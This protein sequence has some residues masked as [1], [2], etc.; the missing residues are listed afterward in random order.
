[1][2]AKV[3]INQIHIRSFGIGTK[4]LLPVGAVFI[5]LTIG[6]AMLIS[7]SNRNNLTSIKT[8]ELQRMSGILANMVNEMIDNAS[9]IA[10]SMERSDR[11]TQEIAQTALFGLYYADPGNYLNPYSIAD[12]P[13]PINEFGQTFALQ[14]NLSLLTQL[15]VNLQTNDLDGIGFYLISPFN[16]VPD[17]NPTLAIWIDHDEIVMRRFVEKGSDTQA[18]YYQVSIDDFQ[19]PSADYFDISSVYSLEP[20]AF[21][22]DLQLRQVDRPEVESLS[23]TDY[24]LDAP[25]S[26]VAFDG[27]IP[28]LR[29]MYPISVTLP[30][31]ETWEDTL[32]P[33]GIL[34]LEQRLDAE[35]IASFRSRLGLDLGFAR[36]DNILITSL[37]SNAQPYLNTTD[38]TISLDDNHYYFAGQ[39][40]GPAIYDLRA[41]V[42]SPQSEVQAL[43]N[44]LQSQIFLMAALIVLI[45]SV[46]V[47]LS[48]QVLVSRSLQVLMG[49]AKEIEK[50]EFSSRVTL[51]RNDELGQLA[52][53]FNTMAARVEELIGSLEERVGARTRDLKAAIDVSREITTVLELE[54]LL[55]E[56][57]K[58]TANTYQLYA[59]AVLLPDESRENLILSASIDSVGK[60]FANTT[61]FRIPMH[62]R[63]S[64][65]AQAASSHRS[66]VVNDVSKSEHYM[67]VDELSE[68]RSELAIPMMLG[69]RFLGVFDVQSRQ[70]H[71]F[72]EEEIAALEI[73]A[74]QTAIAVR[75]AQIF[76]ELRLAR[77]QAEQ[78]NQAKSAFLASVSHELRTPLNSIINFTEFVRHG[79]MGPVNQQQSDTLQEVIVA[80]QHLL[81]LIN[82]VL[83]MSKIE[84]GS[85]VL[86]IEDG[87]DPHS[88]LNSAIS[89][90]HSLIGDKPVKLLTNIEE[91]LPTIRADSQ[92][93]LQILLNITSNACKFT[94]EGHISFEARS[95][96]DHIL[97][98][99]RDTGPGISQDDKELV[100]G[101]FQQTETGL[102]TGGGTGLGSPSQKCWRKRMAGACGTKVRSAAAQRFSSR[103]R[104]VYLISIFQISVCRNEPH[105][106]KKKSALRRG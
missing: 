58:L 60:P 99:I 27:K 53:A 97:I 67:F 46:I 100:F 18:L 11:V 28:I 5:L 30:H 29:T 78:A 77:E 9:L 23:Q 10:Q 104:S 63:R 3:Q 2:T 69:E 93:I 47:Y 19:T 45:G 96:D 55:P 13:Q 49:G 102:R 70:P 34:V 79:M 65:I 38:Q 86:Y 40:T 31:P 105:D 24:R 17:A 8:A 21:Y 72:G 25:V 62:S 22:S 54:N 7:V 94:S 87:I 82:D 80:S 56:V 68:T 52:S 85:L 51:P 32:I 39:P 81:N 15:Q 44:Q 76:E 89:T 61:V 50:G 12:T 4:I 26:H 43:I 33:T 106:E 35:T 16:I 84:S 75:N 95:Q 73:L 1:M 64:I 37:M 57:V 90:A 36:G 74:K 6:L 48:I 42:F 83:D 91:R 71:S 103:C 66:I 41:L 20:Q 92:R 98:A 101:S 88:L 59:V 14:A